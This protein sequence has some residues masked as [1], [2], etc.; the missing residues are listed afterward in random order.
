MI[1]TNGQNL[2]NDS[3]VIFEEQKILL[4]IQKWKDFQNDFS[5]IL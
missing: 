4:I 1:Y 5:V 3:L 2:L